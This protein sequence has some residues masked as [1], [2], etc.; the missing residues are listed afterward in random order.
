MWTQLQS[1]KHKAMSGDMVRPIKPQK[2]ATSVSARRALVAKTRPVVWFT[3]VC[4]TVLGREV[5][6]GS[7]F[8]AGANRVAPHTSFVLIAFQK[9]QNVG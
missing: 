8:R 1:G 4:A 7:R 2:R 5:G 3:S 9:H 6:L